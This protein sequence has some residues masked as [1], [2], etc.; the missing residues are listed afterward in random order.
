MRLF[1]SDAVGLTTQQVSVEG[2]QSI[3]VLPELQTADLP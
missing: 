1:E 2:T 3:R